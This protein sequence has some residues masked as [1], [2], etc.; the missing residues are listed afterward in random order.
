MIKAS[1]NSGERNLMIPAW[2][3]SVI[4][5]IKSDLK[6]RSSSDYSLVHISLNRS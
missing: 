1:S 6:A 4:V 2:S 5:L 3:L